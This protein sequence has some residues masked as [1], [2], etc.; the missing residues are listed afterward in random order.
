MAKF[1]QSISEGSLHFPTALLP[2]PHL[3]CLLLLFE[4][5]HVH[6]QAFLLSD[7]GGQVQREA[8]CV[9]Q[10]PCCVTW[11]HRHTERE[12]LLGMQEIRGVCLKQQSQ[13]AL[14]CTRAKNLTVPLYSETD[15]N[16]QLKQGP[17]RQKKQN[18]LFILFI[19]TEWVIK[20]SISMYT[21]LSAVS[22]QSMIYI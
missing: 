13:S 19:Y 10:Q 3:G 1:K 17:Q 20:Y 9:I 21:C 11:T 8:V 15:R 18:I 2:A 7:E 14:L 4:G 16:R 5:S 6:S 22:T 12:K